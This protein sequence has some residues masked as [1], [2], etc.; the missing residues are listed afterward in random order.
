MWS[1]IGV[2]EKNGH[3]RFNF[4]KILKWIYLSRMEAA[5]F[6]SNKSIIFGIKIINLTGIETEKRKTKSKPPHNFIL[7]RNQKS[8]GPVEARA[9]P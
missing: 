8:D 9:E 7:D 1:E 4:K 3:F 2:F 6:D 5:Y